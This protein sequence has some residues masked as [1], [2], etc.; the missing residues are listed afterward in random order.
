MSLLCCWKRPL[1]GELAAAVQ[2]SVV[3]RLLLLERV[4]PTSAT[5]F[6]SIKPYENPYRV[7][8]PRNYQWTQHSAQ[9]DLPQLGYRS[10][11]CIES[12]WP[13]QNEMYHQSSPCPP[14]LVDHTAHWSRIALKLFTCMAVCV[15]AWETLVWTPRN[16]CLKRLLPSYLTWPAERISCSVYSCLR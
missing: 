1:Q 14:T 12:S 11:F 10:L 5:P 16:V 2:L 7:I 8:T 15:P 9:A 4:F 13:Q 6:S 3:R